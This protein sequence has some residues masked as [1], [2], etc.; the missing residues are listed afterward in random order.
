MECIKKKG[1][2]VGIVEEKR[3]TASLLK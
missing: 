3:I 1:G 2:R